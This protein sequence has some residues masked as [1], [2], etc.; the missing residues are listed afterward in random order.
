MQTSRF[1]RRGALAFALVSLG[2]GAT[3]CDDDENDLAGGAVIGSTPGFYNGNTITFDYTQ[4]FF[5]VEPPASGATS[6][7]VVGAAAQTRPS[8]ATAGS[9]PI[10]YVLTPLFSPT[11]AA[12]TLHCPTQGSCVAH[13]STVDVSAALGPGASNAPLPPHSHVIETLAPSA[14]P[15]EL[16]I[17]GVT[18][19]ATW[20]RLVAG[21]SLATVRA[22]Q[23]GAN[24]AARITADLPTNMFL[25][26]RTRT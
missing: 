24:A 7:C 18:D 12:A 15:F 8:G 22:E 23:A 2:L 14:R 6:N 13:P 11:P 17:V 4:D 25:F 20:A 16:K 5:C 26:F 3:A 9:T 1:I 19:A 21:R 10:L